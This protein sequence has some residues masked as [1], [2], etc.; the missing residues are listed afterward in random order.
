MITNIQFRTTN[1]SRTISKLLLSLVF[2]LLFSNS[3]KSQVYNDQMFKISK[4]LNL[5]NTFYV[6]TVNQPK[7][8]EEA[9]V[10]M[11]KYLDPHSMYISKEEVE[12]M[13]EPLQG[14][15]EGVGVQ[16]NI[17]NDT[18]IVVS[19]IAGGPSEKVGIQAGDRFV[20]ING[21]N[22]AGIGIKNQDVVDKLRG[23]K[24]TTVDVG[25]KRRGIKEILDFR[26]TRDKIPIY[27]LDASYMINNEVGYIKLNRF[28]ATTMEEYYKAVEKLKA[29][30]A[31]NL[32]FDLQGNSGGYLNIAIDLADEFLKEDKLIVYTEGTHSPKEQYKSTNK[33]N[34]QDGRVIFLIDE[35]SASASE[36]VTGAIQDWD[37][38]LII[39]RR[40][41]GKGLVQR[42][43]NLPDGSMIRLTIARYYTPTGRLIQ[44]SYEGGYNDYSRDLV[45]RYNKGELL[46]ED[47]IHFPDSLKFKTMLYKRNVYGGGGIMPDIFVAIDTTSISEYYRNI[48]RK[49]VLNKFVLTYTD[50]NRKDILAKYPTFEEYKAKFDVSEE[51]L[52]LLIADGEKEKITFVKEDFDKAKSLIQTQ[53]KALIARDVWDS[54]EFYEIFNVENNALTEAIKVISDPV[55]YKKILEKSK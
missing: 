26:I 38:G 49:G 53:I 47:S 1:I 55:Q 24:G 41:F 12:E 51:I 14:N 50:K 4:V 35:G 52:N 7:L 40:S 43:F 42:P 36:I 20:T 44:K 3:S 16:F 11:L 17:L 39:G 21:K 37:R 54:S 9:I 34:F 10:G 28:A 22:V 23:A 25:M 29:K 33:G 48:V 13:N 2:I 45:N 32:I 27:S 5:V 8:A 15:F 30:G 46:N 31:K 19:P 6:D 18:I